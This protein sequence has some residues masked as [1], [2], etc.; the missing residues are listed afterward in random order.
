MPEPILTVAQM[1]AREARTWISG[2]PR[3]AVIQRAGRAVAEVAR[4]WT[5]EDAP[6]LVLAGRGHNGDDAVV[7]GQHLPGRDVEILRLNGPQAFAAAH[8]WLERQNG[9]RRA[10]VIDGMFGIGLNRPLQGEWAGL[11]DEVNRAGIPVL[12]VDV[13]SGLAADS[14][15]PLGDA[16]IEAT[17]TV[18]LGAVKVGMLGEAAARYLGRVELAADIGLVAADEAGG[19]EWVVPGDF[20]GWPPARSSTAHKGSFGHVAILAGSLGYHGAAVLAA[21]GAQRA[22]PGLVTVYTD[23][24]CYVP[25]AAQLRAAMVRPWNGAALNPDDHTALVAGPGLASPGL[26][27]GVRAEVG[28]LWRTAPCLM[29]A[30][31]SALDDLPRELEPGAGPRVITPHPGEAGRLLGIPAAEVQ[32]DRLE[33]VRRLSGMWSGGRV[34]V[35]LKGRHTLVG[36]R[37]GGLGVNPSGNPGLAQGGTG[38]VLAGF[39]GGLLAQPG[40][41]GDVGKVLRYGVWEHGCAADR[42]EE[43]GRA[44]T[45]E[46][47]V[48]ELGSQ[49]RQP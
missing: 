29:L 5:R 24:R 22:R 30:D 6:V 41:G 28:R 35:V 39:L 1:R 11:V 44:W 43:T 17:V 9:N 3:E 27:Y 10:M 47:L 21:Q 4:H 23:E 12:A 37:E 46:E 16:V 45:T 34:W 32:S 36:R 26:P 15:Q 8:G 7:A 20:E 48:H 2:M 42:Q 13:P 25:V 18:A 14:G 49:P 38:D 31:A 19:P 40:W 33:A